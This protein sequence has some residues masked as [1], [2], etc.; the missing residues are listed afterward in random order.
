MAKRLGVA[1]LGVAGLAYISNPMSVLVGF[2]VLVATPVAWSAWVAHT[3]AGRKS[4]SGTDESN[5]E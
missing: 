3:N 4:L 5:Y 2:I 1:S